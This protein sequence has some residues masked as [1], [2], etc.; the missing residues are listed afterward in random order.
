[1]KVKFLDKEWDINN[2]TY[3]EKRE[4]WK[5]NSLSW[6]NGE[7][8]QEEYF[9]LLDKTEDISGLSPDD[10]TNKDGDPLSMGEI[11]LVLQHILLNYLGLSTDSKK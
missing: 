6:Q 1:M 11:D 7:L 4:L 2:P 8:N 3:K 10:Y 9:K 5:L